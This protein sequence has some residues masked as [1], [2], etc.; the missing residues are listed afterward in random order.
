MFVTN[1]V[2]DSL[3]VFSIRFPGILKYQLFK[4]YIKCHASLFFIIIIIVINKLNLNK[5]KIY[6]TNQKF[7]IS[8]YWNTFDR[9]ALS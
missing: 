6:I 5:F 3:T 7:G 2:K 4:Y 1:D 9:N 8:K